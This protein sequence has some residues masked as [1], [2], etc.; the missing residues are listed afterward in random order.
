MFRPLIVAVA[1]AVIASGGAVRAEQ[2]MTVSACVAR[3]DPPGGGFALVN[4][5]AR[6]ASGR[7]PGTNAPKS[8]TP[9]TA[10]TGELVSARA[11]S[12]P[13]TPKGSTP[14]PLAVVDTT[15]VQ[16]HAMSA[17]GSV[18][19][20][21]PAFSAREYALTGATEVLESLV[22]HR[23]TVTGVA[24]AGQKAMAIESIVSVSSD[25]CSGR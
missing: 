1:G 4:A 21:S 20:S 13:T 25:A 16:F 9:I 14:L 18:P 12:S 5:S 7:T 3:A 11:A 23:I 15:P 17:K 22:G 6:V 24:F 10:P 8:S 2:R 19:T